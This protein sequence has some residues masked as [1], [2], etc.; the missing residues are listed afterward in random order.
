MTRRSRAP[1]P[2][3][4]CWAANMQPAFSRIRIGDKVVITAKDE[5]YAFVDG[6]IGRVDC[7]DQGYAVVICARDDG[8]KTFWVP[9]EQLA[10]HVGAV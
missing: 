7:F 5:N 1:R 6:W 9:P 10:L 8:E 3:C 2:I 4:N